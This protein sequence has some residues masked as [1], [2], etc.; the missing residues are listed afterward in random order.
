MDNTSYIH[1]TVDLKTSIS[2][3]NDTINNL[4]SQLPRESSFTQTK[5]EMINVLKGEVSKK[6]EELSKLSQELLEV[7]SKSNQIKTEHSN[8]IKSDYSVPER[9]TKTDSKV[10]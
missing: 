10:Y 6:T 2:A 5:D 1:I 7:Q 8:H 4:E 9:I 3:L